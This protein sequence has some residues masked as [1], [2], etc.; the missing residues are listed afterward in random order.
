MNDI[1]KKRIELTT[2]HLNPSGC[3]STTGSTA[4]TAWSGMNKQKVTSRKRNSN[5]EQWI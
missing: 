2:S 4:L 5:M 1:L 3:P